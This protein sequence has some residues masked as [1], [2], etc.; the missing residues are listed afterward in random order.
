[1]GARGRERVQAAYTFERFQSE[2]S[3]A[4]KMFLSG[5]INARLERQGT[6]P[7]YNSLGEFPEFY[8]SGSV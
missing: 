1:M 6:Q 5:N 3:R 4:W 8:G 7:E 2:L